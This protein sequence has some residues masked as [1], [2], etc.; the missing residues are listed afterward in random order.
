MTHYK[1]K[2]RD[3]EYEH[4]FA[5]AACSRRCICH[6]DFDGRFYSCL[7]R[8]FCLKISILHNISRNMHH[9]ASRDMQNCLLSNTEYPSSFLYP[10]RYYGWILTI[11]WLYTTKKQSWLA[12]ST[13]YY[14]EPVVVLASLSSSSADVLEFRVINTSAFVW[15]KKVLWKPHKR[16]HRNS[17]RIRFG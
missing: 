15:H 5:K 16:R 6:W 8:F 12:I 17:G 4:I 9:F 13:R 11:K 14:R 7:C 10:S 2:M 3:F 1:R